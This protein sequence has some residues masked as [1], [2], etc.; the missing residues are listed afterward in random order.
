M[1]RVRS[2][3]Q[4]DA[5]IFIREDQIAD[6]YNRLLDLGDYLLRVFGL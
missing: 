1:L 3:T 5:H 6:E 4:D 2:F